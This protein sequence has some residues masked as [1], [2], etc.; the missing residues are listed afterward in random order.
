MILLLRGSLM[1]KARLLGLGTKENRVYM[2]V[3]EQHHPRRDGQLAFAKEYAGKM[4]TTIT[5]SGML[6]EYGG[7]P[8]VYVEAAAAAK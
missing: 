1:K 7:I 5:I 4:G 8:T 6:S 3:A 2:L